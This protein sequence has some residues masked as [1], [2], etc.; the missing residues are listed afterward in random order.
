VPR[1]VDWLER[2][3]RLAHEFD[4]LGVPYSI[5]VRANGELL[6]T[7][8]STGPLPGLPDESWGVP[9]SDHENGSSSSGPGEGAEEKPSHVHHYNL[10]PP[11]GPTSEGVC[12]CGDRRTFRNSKD[13]EAKAAKSGNAEKH[14][15][16]GGTGSSSG[17]SCCGKHRAAR[18][19]RGVGVSASAPLDAT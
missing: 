5:E 1:L 10:E 19:H 4:G 6:A 17:C 3:Q 2:I 9:A 15:Y 8:Q 11:D 13:E 7:H 16:V 12:R 14:R 18:E